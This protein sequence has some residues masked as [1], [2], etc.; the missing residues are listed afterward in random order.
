MTMEKVQ[1]FGTNR[2]TTG[3]HN[4]LFFSKKYM[5]HKVF[6]KIV[7]FTFLCVHRLNKCDMRGS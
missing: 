3:S 5:H 7:S 2:K 4:L 6:L 1:L